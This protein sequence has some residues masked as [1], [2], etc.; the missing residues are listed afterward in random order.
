[1]TGRRVADM[2]E[3]EVHCVGPDE[4][5]SD[6]TSVMHAKGIGAVIVMRDGAPAGIF[7]ERDLLKRVVAM[8]IDPKSVPV[9]AVMTARMMG[10]SPDADIV[11]VAHLMHKRNFRH[12]PVMEDG[13]LRGILSV[14]D[15]LGALL[16][17]PPPHKPAP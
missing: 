5:V 16:P 9:S 8:G 6:V 1:M 4:R 2:M 15:V 3:K 10:V 11:V 14:R 13:A 12:M 7:S 17:E